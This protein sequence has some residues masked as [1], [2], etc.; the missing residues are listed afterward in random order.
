MSL[1]TCA[2]DKCSERFEPYSIEQIYCSTRCRVRM[3]AR[4]RRARLKHGGGDDG[5]GGGRQR[6]LFPK[7]PVSAKRVKQPRPETAPLFGMSINGMYEKHLGPLET[8]PSAANPAL[9]PDTCY[10]TPDDQAGH[11]QAEQQSAP[12]VGLPKTVQPVRVGG[13]DAA[14]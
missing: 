7:Q 13:L 2:A 14:A 1:K 5:G 12:E 3:G 4:A 9:Y 6:R 10:R 8:Y 11:D